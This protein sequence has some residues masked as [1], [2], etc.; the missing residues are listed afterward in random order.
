V[1]G[2]KHEISVHQARCVGAGRF[3]FQ[4]PKHV[5]GVGE[6]RVGGDRGEVCCGCGGG[7]R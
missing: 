2:M 7:Q 6:L 1:V 3:S 4:H 5:G